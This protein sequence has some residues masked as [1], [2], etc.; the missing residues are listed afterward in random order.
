MM[1]S[2]T[3]ISR[4]AELGSGEDDEAVIALFESYPPTQHADAAFQKLLGA[5]CAIALHRP[6][7]LERLLP[8]AIDP[9]V[10]I[11]V[12]TLEDFWRYAEYCARWALKTPR[13]AVPDFTEET[14][15]FLRVEMRQQE[16]LVSRLLRECL[17]GRVEE[18]EGEE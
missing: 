2:I 7:L 13:P 11:G 16:A 5:A 12:E 6:H 15:A 17:A 1:I 18:G 4:M 8:R 14:A 9:A 10:S 3:R